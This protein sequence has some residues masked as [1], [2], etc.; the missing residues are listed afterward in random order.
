MKK[1]L[2]IILL[3]ISLNHFTIPAYS[4]TINESDSEL[5]EAFKYAL[6]ISLRKPIDKAISEI[7]NKDKNAPE[8]L[9]WAPY[10][11]EILKIRQSNGIGGAYEIT[12]KVTPY[13]RA[14]I[15]YGEDKII[16]T[17]DGKLIDYKHLKTYPKID[18]K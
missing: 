9:T 2:F 11:T 3:L 13:Y 5:C 14:H 17:A 8:D 12:L 10:A 6:I 7:Y 16:V 1:F 15:T 18:F 4:A